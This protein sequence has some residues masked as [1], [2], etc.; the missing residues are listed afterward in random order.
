MSLLVSRFNLF[1][2]GGGEISKNFAHF[3]S[4]LVFVLIVLV[5]V[6]GRRR[7]RYCCYDINLGGVGCGA[8]LWPKRAADRSTVNSASASGI[9]W[10]RFRVCGG[11]NKCARAVVVVVCPSRFAYASQFILELML[12]PIDDDDDDE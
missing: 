11:D 1:P 12:I 7:R 3:P 6:I 4:A 8:I 2:A 5:A 10:H 9:K